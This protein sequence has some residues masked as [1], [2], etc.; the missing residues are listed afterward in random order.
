MTEKGLWKKWNLIQSWSTE[1]K[2]NSAILGNFW[3]TESIMSYAFGDTG[4]K[5]ACMKPPAE[6]GGAEKHPGS[7]EP[8]DRMR[9][10]WRGEGGKLVSPLGGFPGAAFTEQSC[11]WW[12]ESREPALCN[13]QLCLITGRGE[14][15][16]HDFVSCALHG[17]HQKMLTCGIHTRKGL[18]FSWAQL[19]PNVGD[20]EQSIWA[21]RWLCISQLVLPYLLYFSV[22]FKLF[23][24]F[25]FPFCS[26]I[27]IFVRHFALFLNIRLW[28]SKY[29]KNRQSNVTKIE[30]IMSERSKSLGTF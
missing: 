17:E 10:N 4:M 9:L 14:H 28:I 27:C 19:R 24:S 22:Y 1:K 29:S 15:G 11:L 3:K 18:C 26:N 16:A 8:L 5:K 2:W 23:T 7:E 20:P 6:D 25:C 13:A 30:F 12:R 21:L